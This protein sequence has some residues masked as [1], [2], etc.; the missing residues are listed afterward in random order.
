MELRPFIDRVRALPGAMR[1]VERSS[2][3]ECTL[4]ALSTV[5]LYFPHLDIGLVALG[6]P[7]GCDDDAVLAAEAE[8]API[9]DDIVA[10]LGDT[11]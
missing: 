6:G 10:D 2:S 9:A 5:H 4:R 11:E 3:R 1:Q 8:V 7:Q